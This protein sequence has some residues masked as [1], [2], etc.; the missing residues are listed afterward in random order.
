MPTLCCEICRYAIY[1]VADIRYVKL[2]RKHNLCVTENVS[3][4]QFGD[5]WSLADGWTL[6]QIATIVLSSFIG[7]FVQTYFI[8]R[9][10]MLSRNWY[11][12]V[13]ASFF[14]LSGPVASIVHIMIVSDPNG[15]DVPPYLI[16]ATM[17]IV[18]TFVADGIITGFTCWY[19]LKQSRI[20]RFAGT[21]DL[22]ARLVTVSMQSAVLP[23]ACAIAN[24][25]FNFR[26]F[27]Q[28]SDWVILFNMLMPYFYVKSL[29]FTLNSR[30]KPQ[31]AGEN[32]GAGPDV[33]GSH[34]VTL[35]SPGLLWPKQTE[36]RTTEVYV[37][38]TSQSRGVLVS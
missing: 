20:S 31:V 37:T 29:L 26:L 32:Q 9:A 18:G 17:M 11:F 24:L 38:I 4:K 28:D 35:K 34:S 16:A 25:V 30:S 36:N 22:I 13:V 1:Y 33:H 3:V 5:Y 27:N 14:A 12:L 19:L 7:F 15:H 23:F 10:F 21:K 2:S 6:D 8:H